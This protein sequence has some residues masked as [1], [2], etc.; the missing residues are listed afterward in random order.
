MFNVRVYF[1]RVFGDVDIQNVVSVVSVGLLQHVFHLLVQLE[2]LMRRLL[3]ILKSTGQ[4]C[5]ICRMY[6][7]TYVLS[8]YKCDFTQTSTVF[9]RL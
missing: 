7:A 1:F 9:I 5:Q 8:V 3:K 2:G 4:T 6:A